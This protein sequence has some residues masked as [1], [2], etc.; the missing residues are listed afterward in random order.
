VAPADAGV[1]GPPAASYPSPASLGPVLY[2]AVGGAIVGL[3][4]LAVLA[5]AAV[6][7][8]LQVVV[9]PNAIGAWA[10]RWLQTAA[11]DAIET[12]H[13]DATLGG[14]ALSA[15]CGA[16]AGA[17]FAALM[18]RLPDDHPAVWGALLGALCWAATRYVVAPALDPLLLRVFDV[19]A[20]L[21]A[22]LV[23]GLLAGAWV[24]LGRGLVAGHP[25]AAA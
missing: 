7:S 25:A 6:L 16:L 14:I 17:V 4:S 10:I 18:V 23:F 5:A 11:P 20:L 1:T 3:V 8:D 19:T 22:F 9:A 2:G 21:P 12:F 15:L 13:P 24:Q